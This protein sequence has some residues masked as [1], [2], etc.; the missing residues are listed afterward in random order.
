MITKH[1]YCIT[2]DHSVDIMEDEY[3][4]QRIKTGRKIIRK[5]ILRKFNNMGYT[6]TKEIYTNT[7]MSNYN[8]NF[9]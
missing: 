9:Y 4:K 2:F 8:I 7:G 6:P 1:I 3:S 5:D